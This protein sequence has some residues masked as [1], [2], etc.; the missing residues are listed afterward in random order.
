M[1]PPPSALTHLHICSRCYY[2]QSNWHADLRIPHA[3][4]V[5]GS[6]ALSPQ[7]VVTQSQEQGPSPCWLLL[8]GRPSCVTRCVV[9]LAW[10][11]LATPSGQQTGRLVLDLKVGRRAV[12]LRPSPMAA[13]RL[14]SGQAASSS[15][16]A[17]T[18]SR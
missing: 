11:G 18:A 15:G 17:L 8:L 16:V 5:R 7:H 9:P 10:R 1:P 2:L 6:S 13:Q 3:H 14:L 12:L 4:M